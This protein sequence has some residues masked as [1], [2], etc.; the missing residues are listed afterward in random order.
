[1][2]PGP[3]LNLV[4]MRWKIVGTY[5]AVG[6]ATVSQGAGQIHPYRRKKASAQASAKAVH[7]NF[8]DS[9]SERTSVPEEA[10]SSHIRIT[11]QEESERRQTERDGLQ[12]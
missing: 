11:S 12:D 10:K 4:A 9:V 5:P 7:S 1:M 6:A 3:R 2:F 8:C